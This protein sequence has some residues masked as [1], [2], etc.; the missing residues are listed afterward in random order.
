MRALSNITNI[1]NCKLDE[2]FETIE[3]FV[4]RLY[5]FK[6]IN[7]VNATRVS[8]FIKNYKVN[9]KND[10]LK[11]KNRVDGAIF[12]PCKSELRQHLL[13][14]S[15]IAHLWSHA[16]LQNPSQ[17]SPTDWGWE[18]KENKYIFKWFEGDQ[19]PPSITSITDSSENI[20]D[21][22]FLTVTLPFSVYISGSLILTIKYSFT[23]DGEEK[24]GQD[25]E[26][27]EESNFTEGSSDDDSSEN[28]Y[29]SDTN[30]NE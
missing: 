9:D 4:C 28:D 14:T 1:P 18:E 7:D 6:A 30:D 19:V 16:H 25:I 27:D 11:L 8:T 3:E 22:E 24:Q 12:P 5:G 29:D 17:L 15:Y 26:R 10:M 21:M 2:E 20:E 13:R 23:D